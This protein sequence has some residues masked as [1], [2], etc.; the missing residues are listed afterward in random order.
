MISFQLPSI[1]SGDYISFFFILALFIL[2]V[3]IVRRYLTYPSLQRIQGRLTEVVSFVMI[4]AFT[5]WVYEYSYN[6]R[7]YSGR[8]FKSYSSLSTLRSKVGDEIPLLVNPTNP[9][10]S[11]VY[12][13]T[14]FIFVLP[15]LLILVLGMIGLIGW[16][17]LLKFVG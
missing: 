13:P 17:Y 7:K 6:G 11:F 14:L 5:K 16:Y 10:K 3:K 15:D 9:K 2:F 1:A 8:D 4:G 12:A